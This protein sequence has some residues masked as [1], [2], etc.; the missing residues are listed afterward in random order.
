MQR[1]L[2]WQ[3]I[4]SSLRERFMVAQCSCTELHAGCIL[5]GVLRSREDHT[6]TGDEQWKE[7][8]LESWL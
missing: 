1:W 6:D 7:N 5:N 4:H 2:R 3:T 8:R